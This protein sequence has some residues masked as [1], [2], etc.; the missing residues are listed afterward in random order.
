MF[1]RVT[2]SYEHALA[3]AYHRIDRRGVA[4]NIAKRD[5]LHRDLQDSISLNLE[6]LSKNWGRHVYVGKEND[7][8]TADSININSSSGAKSLVNR[9]TELGYKVP[10]VRKYDKK[11]DLVEYKKSAGD[12]ALQRL[13]AETNDDNIKI[14]L[15]TK[16]LITLDNRYAT[17][18]LWNNTWYCNYNVAGSDT[19]RRSS[20]KHIFGFGGNAQNFPEHTEWAPR[21]LECLVA[22]P[23]KLLFK[24]DQMSAEEWPVCALG[25]DHNAI[26]DLTEACKPGGISRHARLACLIFNIDLEQFISNPKYKKT[27]EYYLGK[28]SRHANNYGLQPNR[29]SQQCAAEGFAISVDAA[30]VV[31]DKVNKIDWRVDQVFHEYIKQQ[32]FSSRMLRTPLGRE[33]VFFGLRNNDK[34]F[35][36][37]NVAYAYIP[38]STVGDNT[39]LA[40]LYLDE[41]GGAQLR[42]AEGENVI[43]ESH[44]SITNEIDDNLD[45]CISTFHNFSRAFK[46]KIRF[47]NGIEIEI[48]IEGGLGYDFENSVKIKEWSPDGVRHAYMELQELKKSEELNLMK[49][50]EISGSATT[51]LAGLV[52][53][54]DRGVGVSSS[55]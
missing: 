11:Q 8:G 43:Q 29:F 50:G 27:I 54:V 16:E 26:Q 13:Y 44:D 42:N 38:Q 24:V 32:L 12:E 46:R 3:C 19:G 14:L 9:L 47:H 36:I 35:E 30:R 33:R 25:E 52:Y 7:N 31:L 20:K 1:D 15:N 10:K 22:R 17:A 48:P 34:N 40:V 18:A 28:K 6:K 37:L 4:V 45:K 21:F 5:I 39:G 51:E 41:I 55:L 2:N 53:P 23:G 49:S